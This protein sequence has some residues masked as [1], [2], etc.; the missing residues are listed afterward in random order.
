MRVNGPPRSLDL[1]VC[2]VDSITKL[3]SDLRQIFL[4]GPEHGDLA[5]EDLGDDQLAIEVADELQ[6][7][8]YAQRLLLLPLNLLAGFLTR[9]D[10]KN[11]AHKYVTFDK[12]AHGAAVRQLEQDI[13]KHHFLEA[14]VGW[15]LQLSD[16][17]GSVVRILCHL[18]TYHH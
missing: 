14:L 6:R 8:A 3:V 2:V 18:S 7:L 9:R 11:V 13:V 10:P 5:D 16:Q 1:I 15:D 17:S 12:L 4:E